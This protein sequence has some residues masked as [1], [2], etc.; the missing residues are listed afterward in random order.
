MLGILAMFLLVSCI[1]NDSGTES[2]IANS[3]RLGLQVVGTYRGGWERE[4]TLRI[5]RHGRFELNEADHAGAARTIEGRVVIEEG[6]IGLLP[7]SVNSKLI[8]MFSVSWGDRRYLVE[9]ERMVD[10]CNEVNLG[11]G[12]GGSFVR[13]GD[14]LKDVTGLPQVPE[15]WRSHLLDRPIFGTVTKVLA[16]RQAQVNLGRRDRIFIGMKLYVFGRDAEETWLQGDYYV[17]V[18]SIADDDAVIEGFLGTVGMR[19][20]SNKNEAHRQLFGGASEK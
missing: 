4:S 20:A 16:G 5:D 3:H 10:L 7:D 15:P 17:R 11:H 9:K 1:G 8:E 12:A 13:H 19:V 14:W 2:E 18:L 6:A